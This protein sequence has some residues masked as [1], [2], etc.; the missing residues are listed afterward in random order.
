MNKKIFKT[1]N[2]TWE[3]EEGMSDSVMTIKLLEISLVFTTPLWIELERN[4]CN[5]TAQKQNDKEAEQA[6]RREKIEE[7]AVKGV[8]EASRVVAGFET[9]NFLT[10][11]WSGN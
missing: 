11:T 7:E 4:Y 3:R 9:W 10:K 2:L 8:A 1:L 6:D 5:R